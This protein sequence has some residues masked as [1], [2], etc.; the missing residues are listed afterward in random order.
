MTNGPKPGD[1]LADFLESNPNNAPA[2]KPAYIRAHDGKALSRGQVFEESHRL[3][4]SFVNLL[5][6]EQGARVGIFS[7]NSLYYPVLVHA[8]LLVGAA[9]VTMNPAYSVDELLHPLMD[10]KPEYIFAAPDLLP[11]IKQAVEKAGLPAKHPRTGLNTV[12]AISDADELHRSSDGI[13]DARELIN[14]AQGQ[15]L[16]AVRIDDPTQRDA[17]ICYSSG[18]SGKP[19]GVQLP[20]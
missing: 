14:A 7:S 19:K 16:Q 10:C 15:A 8:N 9:S 1:N 13:Q 11:V 2:T 17:F 6:L 20:Q 3:A 12:W 18:T 4:W 5:K